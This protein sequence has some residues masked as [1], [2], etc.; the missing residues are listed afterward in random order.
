MIKDYYQYVQQLIDQKWLFAK[1]KYNL[2]DQ[3]KPKV[4]W[5][6]IGY[7]VAGRA[8]YKFDKYLRRN[9]Y[10]IYMNTNFLNSIDVDRFVIYTSIHELAHIIDKIVYGNFGHRK[11]WKEIDIFLGDDGVRCHDYKLPLKNKSIVK[12]SKRR[13]TYYVTKCHCDDPL[14]ISQTRYNIMKREHIECIC[15]NCF[16]G[17]G[18][19]SFRKAEDSNVLTL[20]RVSLDI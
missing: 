7:R 1:T 20:S 9:V 2:N 4:I 11:T 17:Y 3:D 8:H 6:K 5:K 18:I 19:K 16:Y 14:V 12:K 13:Q 10:I 15:Q